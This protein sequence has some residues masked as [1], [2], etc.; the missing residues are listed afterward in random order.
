MLTWKS[1][2]NQFSNEGKK[3]KIKVNTK[4]KVSIPWV[5]FSGVGDTVA[6]IVDDSSARVLETSYAEFWIGN[7]TVERILLLVRVGI[8]TLDVKLVTGS[9]QY[10][11]IDSIPTNLPEAKIGTNFLKKRDFWSKSGTFLQIW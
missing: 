7:I 4:E 8:M 9:L 5:L 10:L 2:K 6:D 3:L 1:I 11:G